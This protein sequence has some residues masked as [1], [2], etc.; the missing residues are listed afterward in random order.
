MAT[1]VTADHDT[2]RD[3]AEE[4][5]RL[6]R[7]ILVEALS[8]GFL[9]DVAMRTAP[10]GLGWT[11][12]VAALALA[13]LNVARHRGLRITSE[14]VTWLTVAVLCAAAFSWRDAEAL[15]VANVL[16][17]L[18][19]IA[20]FAMAAAGAPAA[21][22]LVAR[23]RDVMVGGVYTVRDL[24]VGAPLLVTRD[25]QLGALPAVRGGASWPALRAVLVTA[26]IAF[27]FA[28]LLSRADPVF[29]SL[30]RLPQ[31]D[32][33]RIMPH[34][35]VS[36]AFAWWSAGW[37]RGA[38]LGVS[39]RPALPARLPMQ[40][41]M[42]E[43]TASLGVVIA[44]FAI[45]VTLQ[46]RWL[47]AGADVVLATTGLT[48]A[49]YARRGFF[50]LVAVSA[51]VLPLILGTRALTEDRAVVQRHR[52]LSTALLAL[53]A[54]IMASALLRMS[55]YVGYFG[56]SEDRLYATAIMVWLAMVCGALALTVLR[57]RPRTFAALTALSGFVTLG[58]LN[59]LNPEVLIAR[60]NLARD[61]DARTVDLPYLS[62][63]S[64]D[65]MPT[66]VKALQVAEPSEEAC[67]A[68][69]TMR[70]RWMVEQGDPSWNIGAWRGRT[71]VIGRLRP[72]DVVRLCG[73]ASDRPSA[74][75]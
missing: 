57:G 60:V 33:A 36:G 45:F 35:V 2:T 67:I 21:T 22:I 10:G 44:L 12:W 63:L 23:L 46:L 74:A 48:V 52:S 1:T 62:H 41:G 72:A 39:R 49:E 40:L 43:V 14:Q 71:A 55:L 34:V 47:F 25:A 29:A 73:G 7:R 56:L 28:L 30:F 38:L 24:V 51:L 61:T 59:V 64:G 16:G 20:M 11:L 4:R 17:T 3:L 50:E 54:A 13:A 65:A 42:T 15:R 66:L 26:P 9:A 58:T 75:H 69:T 18:V 6:A 19:A 70:T 68:A 32:L 53:V 37:L 8:L 27:V 5:P 31:V